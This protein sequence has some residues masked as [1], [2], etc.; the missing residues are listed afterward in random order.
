MNESIIESNA[1]AEKHL[2]DTRIDDT[3]AEAFDMRFTRLHV[4]AHDRHWL[5]AA[6]RSFCGYG[7]SV[8]ACDAETGLDAYLAPDQTLDGREGASL[9]AFGFLATP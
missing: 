7:S 5:E 2:G 6:I 4:T 1:A 3:F 9:M 8:I